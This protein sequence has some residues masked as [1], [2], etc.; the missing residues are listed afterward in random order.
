MI[1]YSTP[2]AAT[3]YSLELPEIGRDYFIPDQKVLENEYIATSTASAG[4]FRQ[5][6]KYDISSIKR[7]YNLLLD[8]TR[9]TTLQ[10][11]VNSIQTSFYCNTLGGVYEV[12]LT[13][14]IV[15]A[16]KLRAVAN[17]N[18]SVIRQVS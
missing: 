14:G 16:G 9:A 11:M 6:V 1:I 15:P 12:I 2:S 17:I 8:L 5:L 18:I 7:S 3:P 13:A 4:F 10:S